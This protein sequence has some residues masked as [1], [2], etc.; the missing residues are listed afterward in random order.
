MTST[1]DAPMA[2]ADAPRWDYVIVGSGA[3][4][5]TLAARLVESGMRVL[6][7]EAGG[8]PRAGGGRLPDD[9]DVPAFHPFA[10]EDAAM[11]WDFHVRHYADEAQQSKDWKYQAGQGVLYPRAATLGGCTSHNAMIFMLPHDSDWDHIAQ[12]TGDRSW[13]ASQ[14]R[15]YA[16]RVED[17]RHRPLWRLLRHVGLDPT[18]HGWNGWLRTE[19]AMPLSV[20]GDEGL[21]RLL[22]DSAGAFTRGLPAPLRS[23]LRWVRGGLGDP[24]ARHFRPGSFEGLCYTPLATSSHQRTGVR[25]RLLA[26]AAAHP[27]R[28]QIE[29]NALATRV[30]F[31]ADGAACGVEYLKGAHLYKAHAVPS[32][33]PGDRC[34]ARARREVVLCG[35]AFNTPQ[36]LMLSGIG[37]AAEL[38]A[39][40]IALRADLPGVGR[41]L[42]DRYEVAVTHR[43]REPWRVLKGARFDRD[44]TLWRRWQLEREGMYASNGAALGVVSRSDGAQQQGH[45][46]D[47]FCMALLARFEGYF[48]GFS[49]RIR[50]Q[51]DQ[52][53]WAVL[54]AH[55]RNRAGTVRLR[56]ADPRDMPRVDFHYFEEGDDQAGEDLR[57]VVQ[58]IRQVRVMTAPLIAGGWIAEELAPGAEVQSDE[59][60]AD[61]VRHTAWGHH[62]SCSCPIG[63]PGQGGVLDSVFTVHGVPRLRV[64]DASVFPRIPGFFVA[65]A[66]YMVAEKAADALLHTASQTPLSA[67]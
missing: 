39:H 42:Q 52:M 21:L 53:T 63:P 30:L 55:T 1:S 13:A 46:P 45:D 59:A 54:K 43:M 33:K 65:G 7:L 61:Y 8:D 64:V 9:Y 19:K 24:N 44:D 37:A 22:I 32:E 10:C 57:A 29:L 4:G 14:L 17:C 49:A 56:S 5:G 31:D 34:T 25:E 15:R 35:G 28:L 58:A 47:L 20:L 60:L 51:A 3:G 2:G 12:L 41:N 50:D 16:H 38:Q 26:V 40:G 11:R 67:N 23:A 36:L 18:G 27:G 48:P 66:I 62:A 6:L